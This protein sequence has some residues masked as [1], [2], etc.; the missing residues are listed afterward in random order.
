MKTITISDVFTDAEIK[1]AQKLFAKCKP[2]QFN[3][4]VV[5]QIVQPAMPR[6][7]KATGQENDARYF[8]YLLEHA[9]TQ[10]TSSEKPNMNWQDKAM[11]ATRGSQLG[12]II[13]CALGRNPDD[14]PRFNGKASV[15][16]DGFIMCDFVDRSGEG[17]MSALAGSLSDLE[18]NVKGLADHLQLTAEERGEY[19]EKLG[20]WIS[21]DYSGDAVK[22]IRKA[23]GV[24]HG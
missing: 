4:L 19:A 2:G 14:V 20:G 12:A 17:R 7:N 23:A 13:A 11:A 10:A 18:R 21:E 9:I 16:S 6:I 8:G 24:A 22:R 3:K 1:K 15:T 5:E